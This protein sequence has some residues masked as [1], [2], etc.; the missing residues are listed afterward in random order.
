MPRRQDSEYSNSSSNKKDDSS[1][2]SVRSIKK[3]DS[4]NTQFEGGSMEDSDA[5]P[6]HSFEK[7]SK[8]KDLTEEE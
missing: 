3:S 8:I 7:E 4:N 1:K 2:K 6:M 5:N